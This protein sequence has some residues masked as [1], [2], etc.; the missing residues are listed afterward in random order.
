MALAELIESYR[1]E[2]QPQD[3]QLAAALLAELDCRNLEALLLGRDVFDERAPLSREQ[4]QERRDLPAWLDDFL[5]SWDA[6]GQTEGPLDALW[7]AWLEHLVSLGE[8]ASNTFMSTWVAFEVALRD[9]LVQQRAEELGEPADQRRPELA[10]NAPESHVALLA[11]LAEIRDPM[12]RERLLDR[13]RL[14][15]IE[16]IAGSDPFSTDAALAYLTGI[17]ILDRWDLGE[18][19]DVHELLEVFA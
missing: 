3:M 15:K 17:L 5:V 6:G 1:E 10:L 7:F 8:S 11:S 13:A 2:L 16:T 9:A 12:E 18:P 14:Q 4:L 19:V